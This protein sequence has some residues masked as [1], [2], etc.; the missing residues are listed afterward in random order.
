MHLR[1]ISFIYNYSLCC[2]IFGQRPPS[3]LLTHVYPMQPCDIIHFWVF[4]LY[5]R[6][7]SFSTFLMVSYF[8]YE[9]IINF[10]RGPIKSLPYNVLYPVPFYSPCCFYK[11]YVLAI[12]SFISFVLYH[13]NLLLVLTFPLVSCY[14]DCFLIFFRHW[15]SSTNKV[16]YFVWMF[17][18]QNFSDSMLR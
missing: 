12:F 5:H 4:L 15:P 18:E 13:S 6:A 14:F 3:I 1:F 10:I 2:P 11:V 8:F 17:Q 9:P 16:E 7:I